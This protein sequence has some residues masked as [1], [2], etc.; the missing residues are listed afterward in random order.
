MFIFNRVMTF[1]RG[2]VNRIHEQGSGMDVVLEAIIVKA[3]STVYYDVQVLL[4][5]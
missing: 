2:W 1:Q 3:L 5:F 4:R